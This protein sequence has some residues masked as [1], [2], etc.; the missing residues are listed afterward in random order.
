MLTQQLASG[1]GDR[2]RWVFALEVTHLGAGAKE[3]VVTGEICTQS[4]LYGLVN[5]VRDLG[6]GLVSVQP[7]P[8]L[9]R[10]RRTRRRIDIDALRG[11][12]AVA[13]RV[14]PT[15]GYGDSPKG[16]SRMTGHSKPRPP[17][18]VV[19][20]AVSLKQQLTSGRKSNESHRCIRS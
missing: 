17:A 2:E 5:R 19:R 6:L 14:L 13:C 16:C 20:Q 15:A 9:P 7:G 1:Q 3:T 4:P 12:Q 11:Q 8:R 18:H 10:H